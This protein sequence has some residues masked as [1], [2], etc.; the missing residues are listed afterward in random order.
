M[1]RLAR[2]L[3]FLGGSLAILSSLLFA[4]GLS[5][6]IATP[7]VRRL[8]VRLPGWPH[9]QAPL[10]VALL[11]DIHLGNRAMDAERLNSIIDSVNGT[12]PDLVLIA[13]DF[14]VGHDRE[15]ATVRA[16]QLQQPL[17]RLRAPMGVIA[18]LGNHDHWTDPG[19][20]QSA[21]IR[22]GISVLT[23]RAVR[24]GPLA[25]IGVDDAFSHH[26]DITAAIS[27]WKRIGGTP[28]LLTH[29]PDLVHR[30]GRE[31]PLVM[32]GHTHCG[33]VVLPW[34]GPPVTRSPLQHW[35]TLYDP[36]YRCGVIRDFGRIVVVTAGLG[37]GT[38]PIRIGAPPDWW[39]IRLS[40]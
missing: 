13:G 30:L 6:A 14:I 16:A 3:L 26:D 34:I 33:Q 29:T 10:R 20:V 5:G 37:S 21:L 19:A 39:L 27:S 23:N 22:A 24:R 28:I 8:D 4:L 35:R 1:K 31:V 2:L 18:V 9:G 40:G 17:S 7:E 11:A 38:S 12:H 15:G 32:A 25:V 36:R